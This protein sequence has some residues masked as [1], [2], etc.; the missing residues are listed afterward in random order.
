M[1]RTI[2]RSFF[3]QSEMK[4]FDDIRLLLEAELRA[5]MD[6]HEIESVYPHQTRE[7]MVRAIDRYR[8]FVRHGLIPEDLSEDGT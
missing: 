4:S 1:L 8:S 5:A 7:A 3:R 6:A 2:G